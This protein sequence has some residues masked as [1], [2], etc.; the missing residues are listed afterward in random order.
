MITPT[1]GRVVLVHLTHGQNEPFPALVT[2]VWG[3]DCINVAGFTDEGVPFARSSCHLVQD[4][5]EPPLGL[6]A[7]W[8]P[9][10]KAQAAKGANQ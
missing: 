3:N 5:E 6:Y 8:M 7:Y 4:D 9:Y 10:Q 1:I 2:K